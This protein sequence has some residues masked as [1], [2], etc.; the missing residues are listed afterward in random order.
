MN[1]EDFLELWLDSWQ[2]NPLT[3]ALEIMDSDLLPE[4]DQNKIVTRF[5]RTFSDLWKTTSPGCR[6]KDTKPT[7]P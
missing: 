2:L 7:A 4:S 5:F 3:G 6:I 1:G